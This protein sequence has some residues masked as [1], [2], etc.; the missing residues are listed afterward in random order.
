MRVGFRRIGRGATAVVV[1]VWL[2][3]AGAQAVGA[4]GSPRASL[5]INPAQDR[6]TVTFVAQSSGFS[7]KVVSYAWTFGDGAS[8]TTSSSTVTHTYA[9]PS[10][11][12][13]AVKETDVAGA[14]A[15]ASGTLAVFVCPTGTT[16]CSDS[17]S[18]GGSVQLLQASGPI[19][20][21]SAAGLNLFVGSF[22][23]PKCES[24]IAPAA[25]VT[26]SG[27]TGS[28]S[29]TLQYTTSQPHHIGTTCFS[30]TVAFVDSAGKTVHNGALP[31]CSASAA[32]PCVQSIQTTGSSV[33]KVLSI[34]PGDPKVGAP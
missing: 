34:P 33:T 32:P 29:M 22:R 7:S 19:A 26:D 13:P 16:S 9:R 12:L 1:V 2:M 21:T 4:S 10:T 17:L 8:A 25:A 18:T 14:S 27:F 6:L 28:L 3:T 15:S 23:V 30:S 24:A 11:Y 20:G 31:A 5:S